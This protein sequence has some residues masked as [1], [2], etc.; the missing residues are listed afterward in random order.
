M[1]RDT[2]III[3]GA[4]PVGLTLAHLLGMRGIDVILVEARDELIDY[5]RGVGIDDEALRTM[6]SIRMID[7]VLPHTVPD[8]PVRIINGKGR[9][10]ARMAPT[11]REFGYPRRNGFTQPDVDRELL[12]GLAR[13]SNVKVWFGHEGVDVTQDADKVVITVQDAAGKRTELSGLYA[14]GT[15]G[16]RSYIRGALGVD[17]PGETLPS[18]GLVI[19][20]ANDPLGTPHA[21]F[22]GD[23]KRGY[24]SIALPH[25]LRRWEFMLKDGETDEMADTDAFVNDLLAEHVPDP[26]ALQ[27]IRRRVY[28][29]N[30]RVASDFRNR[31]ILIAGD[32]S[33]LMP[34]N[35]GQ[36]WNSGMRD[37]INLGWKLAAVI[38]GTCDD[39]LLD[40]YTTERRD[41]VRAMVDLSVNMG[42]LTTSRSVWKTTLRDAASAV[43]DV[44]PPLKQW[45][46]GM[47]FK[48]LPKY[49]KGVV[50]HNP[51]PKSKSVV[52]RGREPMAGRLF[53]QP[54]VTT[55]N[56]KDILFDDVV[57]SEWRIVAW[58][59]D[60]AKLIAHK[61][62]EQVD[63]L[64]A[65]LMEVVPQIQLSWAIDN[66]S[67][68]VTA[69]GDHTGVF[70][71]WFDN[72]PFSVFIV[73]P[74]HVIAA[75][76]LA[77]DLDNVLR[78]V[79]QKVRL[80]PVPQYAM[81]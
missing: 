30:A 29:L 48:P 65:R 19:D 73:R 72:S 37:A 39:T 59:N 69:V 57:G 52:T 70:Q 28:T 75:E 81:A 27:V 56:A 63:H 11:T 51:I 76:C 12:A 10:I 67:P 62:R 79:F 26:T 60:P 68:G 58:N 50:V 31:R 13:Y 77:Q 6:Q 54:K 45:V 36:G 47:G 33:H 35:A 5:P 7:Q 38:K 9:V 3:V 61:T 2:D 16:G 8:Q 66:V 78:Q 34:V 71:T 15:D 24:A 17:F 14:V 53:P 4:G 20:V 49:E 18:H 1:N 44:V 23:P 40:T 41:H 42:K 21:V 80:T 64:G 25:G 32:A 22:G 43:M 55:A 46:S 74:D